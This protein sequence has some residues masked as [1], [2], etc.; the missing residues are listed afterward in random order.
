[1]ARSPAD[2][3]RRASRVDGVGRIQ[4]WTPC[5]TIEI[6]PGFLELGGV[7]LCLIPLS[8]PTPVVA[9][10][11]ATLTPDE[12]ERAARFHFD[13]DRRRFIVSRGMLRQLLGHFSGLD[14]K[15]I[16][17][18]NGQFGK[19]YLS[20]SPQR[21]SLEFSLSHSGDWALAGFTRGRV[22]G[23]DMEEVRAMP[24]YRELALANFAAAEVAA[25]MAL[26][27]EEQLDAFFACWVRK[28]SYV[29]ALGFGLSHDLSSFAVTVKPNEGVETIPASHTA[30]P[31][32]VRCIRPLQGLWGA[33]TVDASAEH[34][35]LPAM[36]FS[37]VT[38]P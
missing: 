25:L 8:Q 3:A 33:V 36:R 9:Q 5:R 31:Q 21:P 27:Q 4:T 38:V 11:S 1:M 37:A 2:H 16:R 32:Q 24:D 15:A 29:K 30:G 17:F 23:V 20:A 7:H 18:D 13:R 35:D 6:D 19:P 14:A 10:L 22:I 34:R 28:E 26:P 12:H